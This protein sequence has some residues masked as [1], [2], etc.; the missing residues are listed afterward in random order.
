LKKT[1]KQS[2]RR[3]S[4]VHGAFYLDPVDGFA[5]IFVLL[6]ENLAGAENFRWDQ[7]APIPWA[8]GAGEKKYGGAAGATP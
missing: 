7:M 3:E 8:R 6:A 1:I 4:V 5:T 2:K